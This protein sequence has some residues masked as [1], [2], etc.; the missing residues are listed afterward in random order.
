MADD[1]T[2]LFGVGPDVAAQLLTTAGDSPDRLHSEA[3][4]AHLC[5][6]APIPASSGRVRRH[7]L[8]RGGDRGANHALHTTGG[9]LLPRA[10]TLYRQFGDRLNEG[11]TLLTARPALLHQLR[12]DR[13]G[14]GPGP[15]LP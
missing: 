2:A 3:A 10:L 13:A 11:L 5:G 6:T 1:T 14:R 7:H 4:L 8:H 9:F 12:R 15:P